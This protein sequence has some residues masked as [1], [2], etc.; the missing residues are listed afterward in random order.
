FLPRS[1]LLFKRNRHFSD[2]KLP[3]FNLFF[4]QF[5]KLFLFKL[6]LPQFCLVV[7]RKHHK[8]TK[9]LCLFC[10]NFRPPKFPSLNFSTYERADIVSLNFSKYGRAES[11][12]H[13]P[14]FIRVSILICQQAPIRC[15]WLDL[16]LQRVK[17]RVVVEM[18]SNLIERVV[19]EERLAAFDVARVDVEHG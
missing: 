2:N 10:L 14:G 15:L 9:L 13:F 7:L 5:L 6:C 1:R 12:I 11:G 16:D 17:L 18:S 4:Y 3:F 19:D 8:K